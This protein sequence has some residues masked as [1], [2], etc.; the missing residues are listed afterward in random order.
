MPG[1][2]RTGSI[3]ALIAVSL[4]AALWCVLLGHCADAAGG[5]PEYDPASCKSDAQGKQYVALGR[6]VLALP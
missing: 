1:R 5:R 3:G 2:D 4:A 6:R